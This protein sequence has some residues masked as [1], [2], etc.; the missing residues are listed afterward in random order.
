MMTKISQLGN[1]IFEVVV[2]G[3][4]T[5]CHEVIVTDKVL[6]ELTNNLV[7]KKDLLDFSFNFLLRK[8]PNTSI[9]TSFEIS[10]IGQF[11]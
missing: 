1:D 7:S 5:T 4:T 6:L 2:V 9:M 11:F 10:I 8:E 3:D